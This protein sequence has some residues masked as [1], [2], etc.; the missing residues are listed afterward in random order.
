M[1]QAV[2]GALVGVSQQAIG[3]LVGRGV[4]DMSAPGHQLLQAYCSHLREQAAGRASIGGLDLAGERAGLAKAQRERIEMQN[5]VTRGELAPVGLIEEVLSKAGGKIA[6]ILDAIPGAVRRRV[7]S[8][9]ADEIKTIATEIAR[10]RNIAAEM[11]LAD[12]REE[13]P[14]QEDER[15]EQA[16]E[17]IDP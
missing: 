2:F 9:A 3:N 11:S 5:A 14:E 10:V 12:L 13:D 1:T 16:A 6:G 15:G 17:E 7:P 4:L 8:L